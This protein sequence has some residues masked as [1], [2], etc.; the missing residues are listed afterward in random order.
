MRARLDLIKP[1]I[2]W[3]HQP[4]II[5]S[6]LATKRGSLK[7]KTSTSGIRSG[8]IM[9]QYLVLKA[10][11]S[12]RGDYRGDKPEA[13]CDRIFAILRDLKAPDDLLLDLRKVIKVVATPSLCL[14]ATIEN[15]PEPEHWPDELVVS[16][17]LPDRAS[18][19]RLREFVAPH[20][21][22]G[23]AALRNIGADPFGEICTLVHAAQARPFGNRSRVR[24][25]MGIGKLHVVGLRGRGVNVVIIDQGLNKDEIAARHPESRWGGGLVPT[26]MVAGSAPRASHG[27]MV[28]RNVLDIA[29][30]AT[31]YDV[32]LIPLGIS[33]PGV[34]ACAAHATYRSVL[35]EIRRRR[36]RAD[37]NSAWVLVNAWAIFDTSEDPDGDYTRNSRVKI[38]ALRSGKLEV[39]LGH[40][41]NRI[42]DTTVGDGIDVVFGAGNCGQ[43]TS[44]SRCGKHDRGAGHSIWGANAHPAVLTVGAVSAN[45]AWLGYSSQGPGAW[46]A[47]LKPD[48]CAPS[49]FCEDEDASAVNSGT[50][51]ATG[52][53]AGVIAAIRSNPSADWGPGQ[54]TPDALKQAMNTAARGQNGVW[55]D[56]TGHGIL[57]AGALLEALDPGPPATAA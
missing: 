19:D 21:G 12:L 3:R 23:D 50:S 20:L 7:F 48:I 57:D 9:R 33:R 51:A 16:F 47:T 13:L 54:L 32:P 1:S 2:G 31:I 18:M 28:A 6:A 40:P 11:E 17:T 24:D 41:F 55:N 44:S 52:L 8:A 56:R 36:Q 34:F 15:D 22:D 14:R 27:T 30:E 29:P 4:Q 35:E 10:E 37:A 39:E 42:M 46:G 5:R 43:F 26:P 25:M 49:H 38:T 53:A 45:D